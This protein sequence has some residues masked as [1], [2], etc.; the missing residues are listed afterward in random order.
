MFEKSLTNLSG[1]AFFTPSNALAVDSTSAKAGLVV[2]VGVAG[3]T[4]AS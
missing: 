4:G 2:G 3:A 1:F